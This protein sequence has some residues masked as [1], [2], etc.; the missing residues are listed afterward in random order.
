MHYWDLTTEPSEPQELLKKVKFPKFSE[1]NPDP[2]TNRGDE[3][4]IQHALFMQ[5]SCKK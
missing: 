2:S 4:S 3:L 5:S 1:E